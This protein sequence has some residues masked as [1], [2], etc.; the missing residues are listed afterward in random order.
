MHA[1]VKHLAL[2]S[3]SLHA[4]F[5]VAQ[6]G[7]GRCRMRAQNNQVQYERSLVYRGNQIDTIFTLAV[8]IQLG[9]TP[10]ACKMMVGSEAAWCAIKHFPIMARA[11]FIWTALC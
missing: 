6:Y 9:R 3:E 2:A 1:H 5:S 10:R 11:P 8:A 4:V 7:C